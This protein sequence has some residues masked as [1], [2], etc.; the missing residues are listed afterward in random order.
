MNAQD[1]VDDRTMRK[2]LLGVQ[3]GMKRRRGHGNVEF[4]LYAVGQHKETHV[5]SF[6]AVGF[7]SVVSTSFVVAVKAMQLEK[8]LKFQ[9]RIM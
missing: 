9:E 1:V 8:S 7:I 4:L 3:K 6:L 2:L 5:C